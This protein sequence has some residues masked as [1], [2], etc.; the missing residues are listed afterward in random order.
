MNSRSCYNFFFQKGKPIFFSGIKKYQKAW[1][2]FRPLKF[3]KC[4]F[5]G[6]MEFGSSFSFSIARWFPLVRRNLILASELP[7]RQL[8]ELLLPWIPVGVSE[9]VLNEPVS[10]YKIK[11][12]EIWIVIVLLSERRMLNKRGFIF[13]LSFSTFQNSEDLYP[14]KGIKIKIYCLSHI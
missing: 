4:F 2:S 6:S 13:L 8:P 1:A 12:K 5:L 9:A 11:L 3:N 14:G 10:F 7:R